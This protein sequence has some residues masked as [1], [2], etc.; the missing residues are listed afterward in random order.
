MRPALIILHSPGFD[1]DSG[2]Q[3][4][5]KD[6]P[7]Q[8]FIAQLVMEALDEWLLP[9]CPWLDVEDFDIVIGHPISDSISDELR[10][11]VAAQMFGHSVA[12]D[13]C[14]NHGDG[15]DGPDGPGDM[16]CQR[17][18]GVLI[19]ESQD[20]KRRSDLGLIVHNIPTPH[21]I[22]MG[23]SLALPSRDANPLHPPLL[24]AHLQPFP[25]T[26]PLHPLSIDPLS[27]T[28]K[29]RGHP[30]VSIARML[31]AQINNLSLHL[32][33]FFTRLACS[34]Q[35]RACQSYCSAGLGGASHAFSYNVLHCPSPA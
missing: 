26:H 2:F 24:F 18:L 29:Q 4:R 34:I 13:Y 20:A 25:A 33:M 22:A 14:L 19:D 8:T 27:L 28:A 23:G 10:D 11:V 9:R 1:K 17:L 7:V 31:L 32:S 3:Q 35:S 6:F 15:I 16:D 12:F 5:A 30:P 21:F